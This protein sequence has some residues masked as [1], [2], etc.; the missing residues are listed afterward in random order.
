MLCEEDSAFTEE[1]PAGH[2]DEESTSIP[3]CLA[4]AQS[5]KRRMVAGCSDADPASLKARG[6]CSGAFSSPVGPMT[7]S[8]LAVL[9]RII[10]LLKPSDSTVITN[11]R[12]KSCPIVHVTPAWQEMCG[13]SEAEALGKNPRLTQGQDTDF[14]TIHALGCALRENRACKARLINYHGVTKQPFWNCITV[15]LLLGLLRGG[16]KVGWGSGRRARPSRVVCMYADRYASSTQPH[17]TPPHPFRPV[18][19]VARPRRCS[20]PQ[21]SR[22]LCSAHCS[23]PRRRSIQFTAAASCFFMWQACKTIRT[24]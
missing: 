19:P 6:E 9:T 23:P 22:Q 1:C 17:P 2:S 18:L 21:P 10:G 4:T 3:H 14:N 11:A 8:Q 16:G 20:F 24:V 15:R 13:Y 7:S 12:E 5:R